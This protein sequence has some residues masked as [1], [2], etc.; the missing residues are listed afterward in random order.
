MSDWRFYIN[1][2]EVD[3]P[4]GWDAIEF[5]AKRMESHGIDQPFSSEI[6][7]YGS[8]AIIIKS[9]Y[10]QYFT[11]QPISIQ[12]ISDIG[13][14]GTNYVF[15]GFL[16]LTIYSEKNVCDTDSFEVTVGIIDDSFREKFKSRIDVDIDLS[17]TKDL[18]NN[19][20][21]AL[22]YDQLRL[23]HQDLF[24]IAKAE[25]KQTLFDEWTWNWIDGW[26]RDQFEDSRFATTVPIYWNES[27]FT[28]L[29]GSTPNPT[30]VAFTYTN[31][32]CVNNTNYTRTFNLD[33]KFDY[34][35]LFADADAVFCLPD[36]NET[37]NG[38]I[39]LMIMS[40]SGTT[41]AG[42]V[43]ETELL[44]TACAQFQVPD[45]NYY[46]YSNQNIVFTLQPGQKALLLMQ[47]GDDCDFKRY[48]NY[49]VLPCL[50]T[51]LLGYCSMKNLCATL[52]EVNRGTNATFSDGLFVE[53]FLSR[54]VYQLTGSQNR[55][56]SETFSKES[57]GCYW[58]NFLTNGLKIRN[59]SPPTIEGVSCENS[60]D[61]DNFYELKTSFKKVFESL[62]KIFCL[63]WA[64]EWNGL[65]WIIRVES[66][67]YFYQ[68]IVS[69]TFENVG[70]I[71]QSANTEKIVNN[72]IA[73]YSDKWKN[74][75]ISGLWAIHTERNYYIN[76][77]SV[78]DG[79]SSTL[80]LRSNII[81]EGY[82]IEFIRRLQFNSLNDNNSNTSDRP[83]DYTIF[84]IWTNRD[85]LVVENIENTEY[86]IPL[87]YGT[88]SFAPGTVSM[89]SNRIATSNSILG[90][91]Y[92]IFHTPAR[93][94][95][96][97]WKV[98]G[99]NTFGMQSPRLL[100]RAGEYQT[101]YSSL[102][103]TTTEPCQEYAQES[104]IYENADIDPND[105]NPNYA[106]YIA[107][108]II[109]EFTYPQSLCDFLNLAE[110]EPYKMIKVKSGSL[111]AYGFILDISN[112]PDE[113]NGGTT[114]FT[115]L[116]SYNGESPEPPPAIGPYNNA[117]NDSYL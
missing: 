25:Y 88:I 72:V 16:N 8:G 98:L 46:T 14:N 111:T 47:W 24:L 87:E 110:N 32:F 66:R 79:S 100:Y 75:Q 70:E 63:G 106:S 94:A 113:N 53:N 104:V 28:G 108:P 13:F 50:T 3:E 38:E 7:F 97:W 52:T 26:S 33:I 89:S 27:D 36:N 29:Y 91:L 83:N 45:L 34:R 58:N 9:H 40:A 103:S 21:N 71:T 85:T 77:N 57:D 5:T 101:T 48:V 86:S 90:A 81:A 93:V 31:A 65:Q 64:F 2:I 18:D 112:T 60:G 82:A 99:S 10:D 43:S 44:N 22:E 17:S 78:K 84:I 4:I 12:I 109:I 42:I 15:N 55:F 37:M 41:S 102:I 56:V 35:V 92:N 80:D 115:L 51:Y 49:Y 39:V 73:G 1:G 23:H 107:K 69:A 11:T 19:T 68:N 76:N 74:I 105:F 54:I 20:I 6:T 95:I 61:S 117:Y 116:A 96:R 30:G 59:A 114:T 67:E 62:D